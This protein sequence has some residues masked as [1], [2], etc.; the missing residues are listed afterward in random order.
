MLLS[1]VNQITNAYKSSFSGS[2]APSPVLQKSL[3]VIQSSLFRTFSGLI[4]SVLL[5]A[6]FKFQLFL[7]TLLSFEFVPVIL[8]SLTEGMEF[9]ILLQPDYEIQS[10]KC[11][12][13]QCPNSTL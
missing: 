7:L 5:Q 12:S 3:G 6:P 9:L 10:C 13:E 8:I 4:M 11:S 2:V 1:L